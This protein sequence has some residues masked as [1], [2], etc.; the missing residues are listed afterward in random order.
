MKNVEKYKPLGDE[1]FRT[2][3][4]L[5]LF[6]LELDV[7]IVTFIKTFWKSLVLGSIVGLNAWKTLSRV[8]PFEFHNQGFDRICST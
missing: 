5:G 4:K 8:E 2:W 1:C 3:V 6:W 7:S